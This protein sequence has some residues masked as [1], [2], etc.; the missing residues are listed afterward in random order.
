METVSS[1][2]GARSLSEFARLKLLHGAK[3][4]EPSLAEIEKKLDDLAGV[5][6]S[7]AETLSQK[8]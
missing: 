4:A 3:G 2:S 6:Q 8:R 1:A 7:L 5:V